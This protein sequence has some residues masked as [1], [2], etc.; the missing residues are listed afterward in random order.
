MKMWKRLVTIVLLLFAVS[1]DAE[2]RGPENDSGRSRPGC[3][4][5]P[6]QSLL[7]ESGLEGWQE[8]SGFPWKPGEWSREGDTVRASFSGHGKTR[9]TQGDS[10]WK[11]Y[12]FSLHLTIGEGTVQIPFRLSAEG[13]TFYF[14]EFDHS[15]QTINVTKRNESGRGVTKLSVVNFPVEFGREYHLIISAR[16]Q[17]LTTYIDGNLLNQVTDDSYSRGGVGL[18]MWWTTT[19]TFRD[20]KIRHY[21]WP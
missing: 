9:I 4:T 14:V 3:L 16:Q 20:P 7:A 18:G 17:S 1:A 2:W 19:A 12:E 11:N 15:W 6:W 5:I 10:T 8:S 13:K 21:K